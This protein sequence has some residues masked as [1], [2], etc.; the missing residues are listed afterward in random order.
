MHVCTYVRMYVCI[1]V[2]MH[3]C[4]NVCIYACI[5]VCVSVCMYIHMFISTYILAIPL[6]S[7]SVEAISLQFWIFQVSPGVEA[8]V[9]KFG[10]CL[11]SSDT[12]IYPATLF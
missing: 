10:T 9:S 2:S 7:Q 1:Y 6:P 3:V 5:Y 4:R 12:T 8:A 11:Y